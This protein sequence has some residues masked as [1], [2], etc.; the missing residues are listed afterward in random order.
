MSNLPQGVKKNA[1]EQISA[2]PQSVAHVIPA[3]FYA[4]QYGD[5]Q[6]LQHSVIALKVGD[7]WYLPKDA[8]AYAANLRPCAKWLQDKLTKIV[9][10]GEAKNEELPSED[11][12]QVLP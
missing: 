9:G 3:Q 6:G 4:V 1:P 7:T 5:A 11:A 10:T 2:A 8:D 12:V